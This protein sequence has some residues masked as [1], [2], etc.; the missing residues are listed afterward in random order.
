MNRLVELTNPEPRKPPRAVRPEVPRKTIYRLSLY[1]RCLNRLKQNDIETISSDALAR[2]AAVKPTQLRK[3]L[4]YFGHFG[5]RGRGYEVAV[6]ARMITDVLGT[7]RLQPVI[8]VG[9][10]S[11][12]AALFAYQGFAPAGFEVVAGFDLAPGRRRDRPTPKPVYG[13]EELPTFVRSQGVRMAIL[14]VPAEAAQEVANLLVEAGITGILNFAPL[15]LNVP[16]EVMVSH[17]NLASELEHLS[18]FVQQ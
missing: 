13:M 5:R 3:D 2:V 6:L 9:V 15:V 18:Y 14:A 4:A 7:N 8:L 17:V 12:G 16:T 11:L 10:G 1:L